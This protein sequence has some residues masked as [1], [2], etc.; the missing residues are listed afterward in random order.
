MQW[1]RVDAVALWAAGATLGVSSV[2]W[3][4]QAHARDSKGQLVAAGPAGLGI[5]GRSEELAVTGIEPRDRRCRSSHPGR[6]VQVSGEV[7]V[8]MTRFGIEVP[9]YLGVGVEREGEVQVAFKVEDR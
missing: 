8:D 2:A 7:H 5:V 3:A 4:A 6:Q 9:R 1:F